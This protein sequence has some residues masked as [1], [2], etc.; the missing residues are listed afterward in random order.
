MEPII[1][2]LVYFG[3]AIVACE[4]AYRLLGAHYAGRARV[5]IIEF[6][7][8]LQACL[9]ILECGTI[10]IYYGV[11]GFLVAVTM[12]GFLIRRTKR[13]AFVNP[14]KVVVHTL[15][16][17]SYIDAPIRIAM[18]LL[19]A[20]TADRLSTLFWHHKWN[21]LRE[22]LIT[23]SFTC[24]HTHKMAL[25]M[26]LGVLACCACVNDL[27]NAQCY[28]RLKGDVAHVAASFISAAVAIICLDICGVYP[29]PIFAMVT[30]LGCGGTLMSM[31]NGLYAV[32][33][34]GP[35]IGL[36]VADG[37]RNNVSIR[38]RLARAKYQMDH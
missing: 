15:F 23:Q 33:W 2:S 20:F 3:C 11:A 13:G 1:A 35:I 10:L 27:L 17:G 37:L 24:F 38:Q 25:W 28:K 22:H 26:L 21:T 5:Y 12:S 34:L 31:L 18:Q 30:S 9:C 32:C 14:A 6:I 7:A 29:Q 36:A 16:G 19:A 8:T 4:I